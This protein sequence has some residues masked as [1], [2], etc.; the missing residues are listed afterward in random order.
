MTVA[1][2][3]MFMLLSAA[4]VVVMIMPAFPMLMSVMTPDVIR[5]GILSI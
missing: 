5:M 3:G 2:V 1:V 4:F